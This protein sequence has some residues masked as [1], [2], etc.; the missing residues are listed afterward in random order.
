MVVVD[1]PTYARTQ[2]LDSLVGYAQILLAEDFAQALAYLEH[3]SVRLIVADDTRPGESA[4]ALLH[5]VAR[6]RPDVIRVL[7]AETEPPEMEALFARSI[8]H[9]YVRKPDGYEEILWIVRQGL[10]S[11]PPPRKKTPW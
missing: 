3:S 1:R 9:A 10:R 2:L 6:V 5:H 11:P 4:T 7:F 8:V